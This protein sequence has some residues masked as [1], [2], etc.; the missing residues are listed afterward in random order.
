QFSN[1][2]S[3]Y[4]A[5][6]IPEPEPEPEPYIPSLEEVKLSKKQEIALMH[7]SVT[8][9]GIDVKLTTGTQHFSLSNEDMTFLM[10]KKIEI[11]SGAKEVSY[12]D[13]KNH[14]MILSSE[15]M[16]EIIM[17]AFLFVDR[18]TTYRNNL[19][20]WIDQCTSSAEVDAI[21]YGIDIPTEYQS[22]SYRRHVLQ[23]E[24]LGDEENT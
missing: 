10:G 18:Q 21:T 8:S 11:E 19:Y 6:P 7:Q 5:P 2:G 15:D 23:Q 17:T 12:Q 14:C 20:E 22:E 24:K 16:Q 13:S 4:V 3:V 9:N 1:D